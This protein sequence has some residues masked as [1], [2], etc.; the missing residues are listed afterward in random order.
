MRGILETNRLLLR[1]FSVDDAPFMLRLVNEPSWIEY[2]GDRNVRTLEDAQKYL[3][4]GS[5]QLP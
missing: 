5:I 3:L 4:E 1:K 2:I